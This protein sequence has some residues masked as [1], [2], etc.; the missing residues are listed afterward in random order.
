MSKN[1]IQY[2]A[3]LDELNQIIQSGRNN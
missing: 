3:L 1:E 2:K